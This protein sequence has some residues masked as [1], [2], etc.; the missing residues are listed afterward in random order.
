MSR[1]MS[2][3]IARRGAAAPPTEHGD[4]LP[5]AQPQRSLGGQVIHQHQVLRNELLYPGA[6]GF[7][8]LRRQKLV[9][10][11]AGVLSGGRNQEWK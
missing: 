10:P 9:Q 11:F 6:A 8:K 3:A 4:A 2:S 5:A 1:G 7:G